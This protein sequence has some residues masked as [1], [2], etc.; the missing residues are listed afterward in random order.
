[1]PL[2]QGNIH[3][4][5]GAVAVGV[6]RQLVRHLPHRAAFVAVGVINIVIGVNVVVMPGGVEKIVIVPI[7]DMHISPVFLRAF[8]INIGQRWAIVERRILDCG[9]AVRNGHR[10]QAGTMGKRSISDSGHALR[11]G[12]LRDRTDGYFEDIKSWWEAMQTMFNVGRGYIRA[13]FYPKTW[14][15]KITE[16]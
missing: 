8:I 15:S 11:N 9:D 3:Q 5:D 1:M 14:E 10:G 16:D 13:S 7:V 2:K 4:A 12:N 6:A